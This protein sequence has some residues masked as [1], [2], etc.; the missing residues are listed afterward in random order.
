MGAAADFDDHRLA[1]A[2][3]RCLAHDAA[4]EDVAGAAL[5][6]ALIAQPRLAARHLQGHAGG[7]A[8]AGRAAV[9][10]PAGE[11]A[12]VAARPVRA[13]AAVGQDGA[14]EEGEVGLVGMLDRHG[15][16]RCR[17][18]LLAGID[19]GAHRRRPQIEADRIGGQEGVERAAIGDV[20][21]HRSPG[22]RRRD[23]V[24]RIGEGRHALEAHRA[25]GR[26][27]RRHQAA[28][29]LQAHDGFGLAAAS[30][31]RCRPPSAPARSWRGRTSSS[32][33]RCA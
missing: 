29:T 16:R 17:R 13:V 33:P 12:D 6:P 30:R 20:D 2:D 24:E 9:D 4:A 19:D 8:A 28:R 1:A 26:D 18:D 25:V 27:A 21:R 22:P 5:E 7:D 14:V 32:S 23:A 10:L 31:G 15:L 3:R 11:D